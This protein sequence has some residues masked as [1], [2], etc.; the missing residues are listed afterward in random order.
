MT[1]DAARVRATR[2]ELLLRLLFRATQSMNGD[3]ADRIRGC[4]F[5]DFQ[6]SFTAL[7]ANVDT[8]GTRIV[9]I[10]KRIGTSRQAA[11][12]LLQAIEARGYIECVSDPDDG[13]AVIVRHTANGKKLLLAAVDVMQSIEREYEGLLGADGLKRLKHLLRRLLA[14]TDPG[15]VLGRE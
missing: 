5:R 9:T 11:S 1:F 12:K 2:E 3:M 13:R 4:G 7:L 14:D 6:P 15:G 8:E 10:A